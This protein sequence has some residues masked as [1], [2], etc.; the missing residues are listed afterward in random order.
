[1][2]K[3]FP[4]EEALAEGAVEGVGNMVPR[5]EGVLLGDVAGELLERCQRGRCFKRSS[6][7][8]GMEL[9]KGFGRG[10]Y[11]Q[12]CILQRCLKER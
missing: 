1:M 3:A 7:L 10:Q 11:Q 5:M 4:A 12:I 9:F 6:N 2:E 8:K